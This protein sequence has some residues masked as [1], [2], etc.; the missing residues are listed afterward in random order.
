MLSLGKA[1]LCS[2]E[3]EGSNGEE[4]VH[5][6]KDESV[7]LSETPHFSIRSVSFAVVFWRFIV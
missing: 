5:L 3:I 2:F 1:P 7:D 4:C 6:L